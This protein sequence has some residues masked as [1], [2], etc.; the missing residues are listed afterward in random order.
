M[1]APG[2]TGPLRV[3]GAVALLGLGGAVF[4]Y[5]MLGGDGG[6]AVPMAK[7]EVDD[8]LDADAAGETG[9][10]TALGDLLVAWGSY[11]RG[12]PLVNP[13]A[14]VTAAVRSVPPAPAGEMART[15]GPWPGVDPPRM[16]LTFVLLGGDL[17]RA[18][19]DGNVVGIGDQVAAGAVVAIA[20]DSLRVRAADRELTYD[21]TDPWPR[22]FRAELAARGPDSAGPAGGANTPA[23]EHDER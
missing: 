5:R 14:V 18:V 4:G 16:Q 17:A 21:L 7:A 12:T 13:F 15:A 3:V 10:S 22:E 8:A 9:D 2:A 1:A 6:G 20:R 11:R 23:S 19:V